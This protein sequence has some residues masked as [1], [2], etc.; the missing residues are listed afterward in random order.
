MIDLNKYAGYVGEKLKD[1]ETKTDFGYNVFE[2]DKRKIVDV[3]IYMQST[4]NPFF[5][6]SDGDII[7]CNMFKGC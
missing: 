5:V 3:K 2:K 6:I 7:A 4:P 1:C